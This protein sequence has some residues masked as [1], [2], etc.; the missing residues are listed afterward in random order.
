MAKKFSYGPFGGSKERNFTDFE[1]RR[2]NH[3]AIFGPSEYEKKIFGGK[4]KLNE[5]KNKKRRKAV[6][7]KS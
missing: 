6:H 1:K 2:T 4:E 7:G 3:E 5:C